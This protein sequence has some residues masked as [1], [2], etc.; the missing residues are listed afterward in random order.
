M[1]A[2]K[3]QFTKED[4]VFDEE[5]RVVIEMEEST[6]LDEGHQTNVIR[7]MPPKMKHL[8]ALDKIPGD[9]GKSIKLISVLAN[10]PISSVEEISLRDINLK[11]SPVLEY[12]TGE[13]QESGE[14]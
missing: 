10:I 12:L 8:R 9:I 6:L 13:S 11:I 14:A 3:P 7:L 5:G 2:N 1:V 4:L